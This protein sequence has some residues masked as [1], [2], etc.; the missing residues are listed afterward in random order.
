MTGAEVISLER[1]RMRRRIRRELR[2]LREARE[3]YENDLATEERK[4]RL[5]EILPIIIEEVMGRRP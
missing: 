2:E 1:E 5:D 4:R 3:K